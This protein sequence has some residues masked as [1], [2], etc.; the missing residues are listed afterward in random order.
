MLWIDVETTGIEPVECDLLEVAAV[1]TDENYQVFGD[2]FQGVICRDDVE[3]FRWCHFTRKMHTE[4]GLMH[5]LALPILEEKRTVFALNSN[6]NIQ[7]VRH[8][9]I[10]TL[11]TALVH[12]YVDTLTNMYG[13][14]NMPSK[15][16]PLAG[17]N[18]A[19]DRGWLELYIQNFAN[20]IHYR[21]F[22]M[23]TLYYFFE[24]D[25]EENNRP[26]RGLD[27]LFQ[28]IDSLQKFKSNYIETQDK[29]WRYDELCE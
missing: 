15:G 22:D 28:D 23:N 17:S 26:H 10:E 21:S 18:P 3:T 25:K 5:E 1:I 29:A 27:D 6:Q 13:K 24:S 14:D 19:F 2:V 8:N 9:D 4:N 7:Y 11:Q 12:W 20:M 16:L